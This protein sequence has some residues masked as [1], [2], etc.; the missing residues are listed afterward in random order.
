MAKSREAKRQRNEPKQ[1]GKN[2]GRENHQR[3]VRAGISKHV[4]LSI[5]TSLVT[6]PDHSSDRQDRFSCNR[7]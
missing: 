7:W 5:L 3:N 6:F 2:P 1:I 4:L